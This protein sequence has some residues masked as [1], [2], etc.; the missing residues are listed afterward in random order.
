METQIQFRDIQFH[1]YEQAK[2]LLSLLTQQKENFSVESFVKLCC[3]LNSK[4]RIICCFYNDIEAEIKVLVAMGTIFIEE[5]L[6]HNCSCV[7]HIED[8]VVH[9]KYRNMNFGKMLIKYLVEIA[10]EKQA[11]K[12]ILDSSEEKKKFYQKCGFEQSSIQMR[13]NI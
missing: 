1:D 4:H 11:Y 12:V 8:I 5:K 9:D 6:I 10:R 3:S 13:K 2:S 7:G